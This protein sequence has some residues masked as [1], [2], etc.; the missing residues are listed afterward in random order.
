MQMVSGALGS[1]GFRVGMVKGLGLMFDFWDGTGLGRHG[2]GN[3]LTQLQI[4][5]LGFGGWGFGA[6]GLGFG[7]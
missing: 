7:I 6:E 4:S 3:N 2:V 5:G 1:L